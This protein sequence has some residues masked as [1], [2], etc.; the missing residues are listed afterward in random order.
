MSK[1]NTK[2]S[3]HSFIWRRDANIHHNKF[4]T[5]SINSKDV[6]EF[7]LNFLFFIVVL[8]DLLNLLHKEQNKG[9]AYEI[10]FLTDKSYGCKM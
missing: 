9:K 3:R 8:A 1:F 4:R 7:F 5:L 2:G 10:C 6:K